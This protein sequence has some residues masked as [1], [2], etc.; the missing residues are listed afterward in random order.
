MARSIDELAERLAEVHGNAAYG[1]RYISVLLYGIENAED[2]LELSWADRSA[3]VRKA[4]VAFI[5]IDTIRT[6]ARL[7]Q[8]IGRVS[9]PD[10]LE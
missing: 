10:G 5:H 9:Y 6:G 7:S 3:L 4:G 2:I 8:Y 1:D